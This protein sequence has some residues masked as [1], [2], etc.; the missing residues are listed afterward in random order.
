MKIKHVKRETTYSTCTQNWHQ[1]ETCAVASV[2]GTLSWMDTRSQEGKNSRWPHLYLKEQL[3]H[4]KLFY[5]T[6]NRLAKSL[7]VRIKGKD[8][9]DNITVKVCYKSPDWGKKANE[10]YFSSSRKFL[11]MTETSYCGTFSPLWHLLEGQ[12]SMTQNLR[13]FWKISGKK[14]SKWVNPHL[15]LSYNGFQGKKEP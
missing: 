6:D 7:W 15:I 3:Q 1:S 11:K 10:D 12:H 14:S 9:M 2:T 5:R 4:K 8:V 13:G